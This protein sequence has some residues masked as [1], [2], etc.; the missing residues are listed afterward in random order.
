MKPK[1]EVMNLTLTK[2]V[3][4]VRDVRD[5]IAEHNH[6]SAWR[7]CNEVLSAPAAPAPPDMPPTGLEPPGCPTPGACSCV[8]ADLERVKAEAR[9][10]EA[11]WWR[12]SYNTV[13]S[14]E[15]RNIAYNSR[16]VRIA[17][18]Q[19]LASKSCPHCHGPID[20]T[21]EQCLDRQL[22]QQ[23]TKENKP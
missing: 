6:L 7:L 16:L 17:E 5:L 21:E 20:R 15:H 9:L 23:P 11:T 22:E 3:E 13:G 19:R 10:E 14:V 12:D 18:L 8:S 2:L 1:E 4:A